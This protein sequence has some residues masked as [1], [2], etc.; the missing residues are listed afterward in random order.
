[1]VS[2]K[3]Q[4]EDVIV[5]LLAR[6]SCHLPGNDWC[7]DWHQYMRNNHI[8][9]GIC[10]HHPLHPVEW[11]ERI[12]LLMG[13]ISFGLAL[14]TAAF[15]LDH[16]QFDP[17]MDDPFFT[18]S[19]LGYSLE[20]N[21][22][23]AALWTIGGVC[24]S[25]F[26]FLIWNIM[27]CAC[28]HPGGRWGRD[29][30]ANRC[31]DV[32]SYLMIPIILCLLL[33]AA[34]EVVVRAALEENGGSVENVVNGDGGDDDFIDAISGIE[35]AQSFSFLLDYLVEQTLVWT[36]YFPTVA[37]VIFSGVLGCNG[38]LPVLGGRP[39]DVRRMEENEFLRMK[40]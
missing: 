20:V 37:T 10:F 19:A 18:I 5:P 23:M 33:F 28:C 32:G 27:A 31:K 40:A 9:A 1:M 7:A 34:W 3:S 22:G 11:W 36:I 16:S 15:L 13:S 12:L 21:T 6:R 29:P 26:E 24:H 17:G 8:V 25:L 2:V 38:L 30:K 14:T 35:N 39:R 4:K